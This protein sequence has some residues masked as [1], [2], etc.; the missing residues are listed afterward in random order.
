MLAIS[1]V[2]RRFTW[3]LAG[4]AGLLVLVVAPAVSAGAG[5]SPNRASDYVVAEVPFATSGGLAAVVTQEAV[6]LCIQPSIDTGICDPAFSPIDAA[7]VGRTIWTD[8]NTSNGLMLF[9]SGSPNFDGFVASITNG[10]NDWMDVSDAFGGVGGPESDFFGSQVGPS[11]VDLYGYAIHRVGLRVDSASFDTPG[12]NP[13]GNGNWTD[14]AL[15]GTFVFEGTIANPSACGNGGWR[16]LHGPDE[17]PFRSHLD[18]VNF[19]TPPVR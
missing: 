12:S 16:Y 13:N 8:E 5:A 4:I 3:R 15:Q 7:S 1:V 11:G 14:Y 9:F 10:F 17:T 18:C 2:C 19:S 6:Q